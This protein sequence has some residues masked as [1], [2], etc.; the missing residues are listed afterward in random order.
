MVYWVLLHWW[1]C[2]AVVSKIL[3]A[4]H[5]TIEHTWISWALTLE[6]PWPWCWQFWAPLL[7]SLSLNMISVLFIPRGQLCILLHFLELLMLLQSSLI[8]YLTF[9]ASFSKDEL[10]FLDYSSLF[11]P[12]M[13]WGWA[14]IQTKLQFQDFSSCFY[15]GQDL[16]EFPNANV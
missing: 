15:V 13:Q 16:I 8:W 2:K 7:T 1:T 9:I 12:K 6:Q 3:I 5:M 4:R 11:Q 14:E 10:F